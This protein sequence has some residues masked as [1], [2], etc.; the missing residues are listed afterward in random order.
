L[1]WQDKTDF[2]EIKITNFK[3]TAV[4]KSKRQSISALMLEKRPLSLWPSQGRK[5]L[6]PCPLPPW[7]SIKNGKILDI[8]GVFGYFVGFCHFP[9]KQ[10]F[11]VCPPPENILTVRSWAQSKY[12]I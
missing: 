7:K 12:V 2:V 5:R 6:V 1:S 10:V 3:T 9:R 4:V 8:L 11:S